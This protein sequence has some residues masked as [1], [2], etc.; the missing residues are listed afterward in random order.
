[1]II[2]RTHATAIVSI[3][4]TMI[5]CAG[6]GSGNSSAPNLTPARPLVGTWK[7]AFATTVNFST[8]SCG[9]ALNT[10][11]LAGTQPWMFTFVITPG[12]DE[13]HVYV[14]MSFTTG[15]CAAAASACTDPIIVPEVSPMFF[16]GVIS[17]TRLTL[18]KGTTQVGVF[19]FTTSILT[20]TFD[21]TWSA[22]YSQREYTATNGLTLLKQ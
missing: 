12:A 9:N 1:M 6:S 4:L 7:A 20:G 16:T 21:Y 11:T 5:S 10:M 18:Y 14:N 17:S 19:N 22:V 13:N 8:D 2:Q 3:I 15:T